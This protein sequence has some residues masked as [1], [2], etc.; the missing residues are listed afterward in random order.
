[1]L[2]PVLL[3]TVMPTVGA[4]VSTL[5]FRVFEAR[6]LTP[7]AVAVNR[8]APTTTWVFAVMSLSLAL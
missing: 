1:M 3:V 6:L 5:K 7:P 2:P 4:V 8:S